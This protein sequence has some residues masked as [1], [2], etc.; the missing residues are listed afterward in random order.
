MRDNEDQNNSEYGHF[1][2]NNFHTKIFCSDNFMEVISYNTSL[3]LVL[4]LFI[5][6]NIKIQYKG[7]YYPFF[8]SDFCFR[9][10]NFI[11][12]FMLKNLLEQPIA[13]WLTKKFTWDVVANMFQNFKEHSLGVK[14]VFWKSWNMKWSPYVYLKEPYMSLNGCF[15]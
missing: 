5:L 3:F 4:K 11:C 9:W 12:C 7:N 1:S 15:W 8:L 6:N 2:S 13:E 10:H 14:Q